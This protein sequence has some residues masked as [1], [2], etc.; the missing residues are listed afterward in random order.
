MD[1][2]LFLTPCQY[3]PGYRSLLPLLLKNISQPDIQHNR[4]NKD[5]LRRYSYES[6]QPERPAQTQ[7]NSVSRQSEFH[8]SGHT[9]PYVVKAVISE[10]PKLL[11]MT[12]TMLE[13]LSAYARSIIQL[14]RTARAH[15]SGTSA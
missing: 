12:L 10:P 14:L 5:S 11:L 13:N 1:V 2:S 8:Y 7:T 15:S 4:F 9:A 3:T 6:T